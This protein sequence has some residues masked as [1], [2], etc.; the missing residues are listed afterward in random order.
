MAIGKN[1][2]SDKIIDNLLRLAKKHNVEADL[3]LDGSRTVHLR[4]E[5]EN[6]KLIAY[7]KITDL[8]KVLTAPE[9][10]K[11]ALA[12][13]SHKKENS[14]N[15]IEIKIETGALKKLFGGSS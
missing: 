13:I 15:K 1:A 8:K 2:G 4:L 10:L 9:L 14:E 5:K 11:T 6:E 7:V 12:F 3:I